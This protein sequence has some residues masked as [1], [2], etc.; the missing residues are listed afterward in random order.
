[1]WLKLNNSNLEEQYLCSAEGISDPFRIAQLLNKLKRKEYASDLSAVTSLGHLCLTSAK[2]WKEDEAKAHIFNIGISSDNNELRVSYS[3]P[4]IKEAPLFA[5]GDEFEIID[6]V[7]DIMNR[8]ST[9][10]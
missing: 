5:R 10:S 1:M 2:S 7:D 9:R 3:S 6:F 4:N 8:I